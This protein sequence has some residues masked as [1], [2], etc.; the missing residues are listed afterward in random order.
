M[1]GLLPAC[2]GNHPPEPRFEEM[3]GDP[4]FLTLMASDSVPMDGFLKLV[5][6]V[7]RRLKA[8]ESAGGET[9]AVGFQDFSH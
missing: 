5:T 3:Q 4:V 2:R 7:R 1:T 9:G 8:G 6:S